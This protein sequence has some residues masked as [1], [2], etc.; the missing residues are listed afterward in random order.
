MKKISALERYR[1]ERGMTQ[2][3]LAAVC[4]ITQGMVSEYEKGTKLPGVKIAYRISKALGVSI[5]T[6]WPE[7]E[8]QTDSAA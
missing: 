5:E 2:I 4:E 3:E 6:L 8:M 1:R 7:N